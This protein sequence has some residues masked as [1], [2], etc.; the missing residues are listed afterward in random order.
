MTGTKSGGLKCRDTN[1]KKYGKDFYRNMGRKGGLVCGRKG[2]AVNPE[3][4]KKAGRIGGL[5]SRRGKAHE[6]K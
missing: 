3:L 1:Y 5:K 4:A 6:N 2:F